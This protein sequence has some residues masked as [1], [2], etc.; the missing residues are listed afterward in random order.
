MKRCEMRGQW[1]NTHWSWCV[2]GRKNGGAVSVRTLPT[3]SEGQPRMETPSTSGACCLAAWA[4]CYARCAVCWRAPYP[5]HF[6]RVSNMPYATRARSGTSSLSVTT[7]TRPSSRLISCTWGGVEDV[8]R[9]VLSPESR[10]IEQRVSQRPPLLV[11]INMPCTYGVNV[12]G[13]E[14]LG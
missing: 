10:R 6:P 8:V 12:Q 4:G 11:T 14:G 13:V 7:P 2:E 3:S 9:L 5:T 1:P